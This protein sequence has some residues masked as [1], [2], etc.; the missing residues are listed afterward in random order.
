MLVR[1]RGAIAAGAALVLVATLLGQPV[2]GAR[3]P[4][5]PP[6]DPPQVEAGVGPGAQAPDTRPG[7]AFAD[8]KVAELQRTATDVQRELADLSDRVRVA[9]DEL[10]AAA[11]RVGE[12][13]SARADADRVVA[14][15]QTE[16][17]EYSAALY[18]ALAQP[19]ALQ[20]LL[21]AGSPE[22]FLQGTSLIGRVRAD[23]DARLADAVRRQSAAIEAENAATGAERSAAERK[24]DLDRRTADASNRAAAVSSELRG[25]VDD[26]NAAVVA[27][28][29][30]QAERNR[31]TA[32]NWKAYTDKLA[33]VGVV[34]PKA[35]A[36]RDPTRLPPGLQSVPGADGKPQA[37]VA[38]VILTDGERVLVLP[39]ETVKAVD[40]A[41]SALGKPYV[42]GKGGEGPTAFSCDGLVRTVYAAGGVPLPPS[43]GEQ[44][45][46]LT[47]VPTADA[48]SGDIVFL[49]PARLGAQGVGI[50]L[51]E[52]TMLA[53]D[54]RLAGVVVTDLPGG[55]TVLGIGRP[56]LAQRPPQ[57]PPRATDGG[58]PWRCG[59]VQLPPR[60][61]GEA[62]GA[63]GGYPNGLIPLAALCPAGQGAHLL[64]CDAAEAFR[65]MSAAF[66]SAFGKPLCMTDSYRT[67]AAQVRLYGVKPALAA[68]PGTSNHGWGMAV[69]LCG[70]VQSFG[71]PEYAWMVAN[72]GFFGWSNPPWARP[73]RGREEPWHWEFVGA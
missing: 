44:M 23:Q 45:A 64:R 62:P 5:Q 48:R 33:A 73:G 60:A 38:Q 59:G 13:K 68:V 72:A 51:D 65:A 20:V 47:P 43:V 12:A 27:Q 30:A 57:E 41:V 36:L 52:R 28:Q 26:T 63:W 35:A 2:A 40:T 31:K 66:A 10:R 39:E 1:G 19:S 18:S 70:G 14:A 32:A 6:T 71:T 25:K 8:P 56:A 61:A 22:D 58:L 17:D 50:V 46:V 16:V 21:T 69:D 67:F 53:A 4:T 15:Q 11:G 37:G 55:D 24:A 9:E 34:A 3:Q 54:A 42:P 49:G 29:Q 7:E